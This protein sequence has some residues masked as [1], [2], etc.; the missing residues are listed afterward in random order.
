MQI[1]DHYPQ[2]VLD[3]RSQI[4]ISLLASFQHSKQVRIAQ[5]S[6]LKKT[7]R[8]VVISY[9]YCYS[10]DC[11]LQWC[12]TT[13]TNSQFASHS[14]HPEQPPRIP[15]VSAETIIAFQANTDGLEDTFYSIHFE[16]ICEFQGNLAF[17]LI[18]TRKKLVR[19][20]RMDSRIDQVQEAQVFARFLFHQQQCLCAIESLCQ[21]RSKIA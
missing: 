14:N 5:Q 4:M 2:G 3:C 9:Y 8:I 13:I 15:D 17:E 1:N 20:A 21:T 18:S 7:L 11:S 10:K 16:L 12:Y 19:T 6:M